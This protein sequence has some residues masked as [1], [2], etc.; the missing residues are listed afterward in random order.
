MCYLIFSKD[1]TSVLSRFRQRRG[2]E[3]SRTEATIRR[4]LSVSYHRAGQR[5]GKRKPYS[6]IP[7]FESWSGSRLFRL[8]S[9]ILFL[10]ISKVMSEQQLRPLASCSYVVLNLYMRGI[11]FECQQGRRILIEF[12][13]GFPHT[14]Q[15]NAGTVLRLF[16]KHGHIAV[17]SQVLGLFP[18]RNTGCP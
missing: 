16:L 11:Q 8:K 9:F 7:W 14:V 5:G 10:I 17:A 12:F 6:V 1:G 3:H 2:I 15:E 4:N 18:G 13:R